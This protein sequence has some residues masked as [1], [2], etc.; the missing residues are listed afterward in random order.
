MSKFSDKIINIEID[1]F[2]IIPK[3]QLNLDN[4]IHIR[5]RTEKADFRFSIQE[6]TI[7]EMLI[8]SGGLYNSIRVFID[9][10][11]TDIITIYFPEL[12]KENENPA[13]TYQSLVDILEFSIVSVYK[14]KNIEAEFKTRIDK[15]D[16]TIKCE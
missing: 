2:K 3:N 12:L 4:D 9:A 10:W 15:I 11:F 6:R 16:F 1:I 8:C 7:G 5:F 14:N 13:K